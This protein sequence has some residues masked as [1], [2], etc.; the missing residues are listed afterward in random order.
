MRIIV[1]RRGQ[2]LFEY[3]VL[4]AIIIA[5]LLNMQRIM[6]AH[7]SGAW[8]DAL[9]QIGH[10]HQY[11]KGKTTAPAPAHLSRVSWDYFR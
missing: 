8:R 1:Q 4:L 3:V 6:R 9:D 2:S 7:V 11:E 5:A 10:G